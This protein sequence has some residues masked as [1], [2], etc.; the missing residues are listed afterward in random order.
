MSKKLN[1]NV[2]KLA[3]IIILGFLLV[4]ISNNINLLKAEGRKVES[5]NGLKNVS[6]ETGETCIEKIE[7]NDN[8]LRVYY[9][10]VGQ[11]DSILVVNNQKTMLI[12]AG[13]NDDGELIVNNLKKLGISRIDYLIGTHPHE[14]HIGGLD[15]IID[16][17]D[18]GTIYMP[19]TLNNTKT[20]ED[21]LDSVAKKQLSITT[22]NVGDTFTIGDASCQIMSVEDNSE[23]YNACSIVIRM[24][25]NDISYLFMGDAE[26]DNEQARSWPQTTI[27]KVGHHGSS[28]SSCED[29][30]KQVM[31]TVSIISVGTDNKYGHPHE[32]TITRLNNI[33]STIY[34]TNNVGNI[35]VKQ[36]K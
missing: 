21:V 30:L 10:D 11:A 32:E 22:P 29:F 18:I 4:I 23:N 27:L 13:N 1:N 19:K 31:P 5:I 9:F 26:T 33:G 34:Q 12:D 36:E 35:L 20:F 16:N 8:N 15:N 25:Q 14:D 2:V 7:E 24:V 3:C 17:F 28:T 6:I